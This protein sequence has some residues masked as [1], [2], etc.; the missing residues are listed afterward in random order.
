MPEGVKWVADDS[1]TGGNDSLFEHGLADADEEDEGEGELLFGAMVS[2][3]NSSLSTYFL[4]SRAEE[5]DNLA[6]PRAV[7]RA[8]SMGRMTSTPQRY[9]RIDQS[10]TTPDSE[11]ESSI[12]LRPSSKN[13]A[14]KFFETCRRFLGFSF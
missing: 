10:H 5:R 4:R 7:R 9:H 3:S 12:N 13:R 1:E 8:F 6:D 11:E 2:R 14:G